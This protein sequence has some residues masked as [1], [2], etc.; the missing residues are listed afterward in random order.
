MFNRVGG[1]GTG[2]TNYLHKSWSLSN[3]T[4][5]NQTF[6]ANA[7][8]TAL[9]DMRSNYGSKQIKVNGNVVYSGDATDKIINLQSGDVL[10]VNVVMD[11]GQRIGLVV[12]TIVSNKPILSGWI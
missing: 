2:G 5:V 6:T 8:C 1:G 10:N 9:I 11:A 7:T 3:G 12:C 4:I